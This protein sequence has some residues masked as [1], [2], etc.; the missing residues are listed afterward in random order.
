MMD[1]M[2]KE[3]TTQE[4]LLHLYP[5]NNM[6]LLQSL[7][8]EGRALPPVAP[9]VI[10]I[11]LLQRSYQWRDDP[12]DHVIASKISVGGRIRIHTVR[13]LHIDVRRLS[14]F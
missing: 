8:V 4:E 12:T 2:K 14:I 1:L 10:Q 11:L 13:L 3:V 6:S 5:I 9:E 7:M